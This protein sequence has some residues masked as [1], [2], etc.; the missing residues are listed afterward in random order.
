MTTEEQLAAVFNAADQFQPSPDLFEKVTRSIAEDA[1][2]RKRSRH[3]AVLALGAVTFVAIYL[4]LAV[5]R[6]DGGLQMTF[7]SLEV[8]MT[9]VMIVVVLGVGPTIRRF[10]NAFESDIFRS[11]PATGRSFLTLMDVAFYLTFGAYTFMTLQYAPPNDVVGAQH[12]AEWVAWEFERLAGLLL[13]MGVL[14]GLTMAVL[15]AIGLVFSAN[16][17][18]ARRSRLGNEALPPDH[19]NEQV[20]LWI[21]IVV[22]VLVGLGLLLLGFVVLTG[23]VGLGG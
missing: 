12:L 21:T 15:P 14:H 10:G 19:T 5:E 23:I 17:R 18:Q 3:L 16:V 8:L 13:L 2:H 7:W 6:V 22:W 9:G 20:D 11:G 1:A 4:F